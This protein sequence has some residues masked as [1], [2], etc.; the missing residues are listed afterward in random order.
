MEAI[1]ARE[2]IMAMTKSQVMIVIQITPAV[3]PLN[4]PK[5]DDLAK[6]QYCSAKR[7]SSVLTAG[8]FP[9]STEGQQRNR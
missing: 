3:P 2:A 9:M 5:Y 1:S 4:R 8:R 7:V 6:N